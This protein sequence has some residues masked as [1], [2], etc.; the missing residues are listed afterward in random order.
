[1]NGNSLI[2]QQD[3]DGR[4]K[5]FRDG[6]TGMCIEGT[7]S[8]VLEAVGSWA[9]Y[10]KTVEIICVPPAV[11]NEFTITNQHSDLTFEASMKR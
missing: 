5:C 8:S 11:L 3:H 4:F 2:V 10:S 9:I 7:G 1:M 6:D